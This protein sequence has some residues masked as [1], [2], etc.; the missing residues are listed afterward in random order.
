LDQ[1]AAHGS[2]GYVRHATVY[3]LLQDADLDRRNGANGCELLFTLFSSLPSIKL[4]TCSAISSEPMATGVLMHCL[5]HQDFYKLSSLPFWTSTLGAWP[6]SS[7]GRGAC[8]M[9]L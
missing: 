6:M 2:P 4:P 1:T 9:Q 8:L 3:G 7:T 5:P